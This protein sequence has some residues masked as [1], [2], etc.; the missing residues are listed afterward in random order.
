MSAAHTRRYPGFRR[1]TF[2]C[3]FILYAPLLVVTVYSFN[4]LRSITTW[5][6]FSLA[7]YAKAINNP[8][9]QRRPRTR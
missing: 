4:S 9:I 3:L 1:S 2:V 8:A 6:G 5:G 7:W